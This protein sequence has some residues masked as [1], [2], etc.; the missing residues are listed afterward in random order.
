[1]AQRPRLKSTRRA[2]PPREWKGPLT[3]TL[4]WPPSVNGY[5]RAIVTGGRVRQILS[6]D[7]RAY[8]R[9]AQLRLF[10]QRAVR[11]NINTPVHVYIEAAEPEGRRRRDLDNVLKAALDAMVHAGI[12]EDDCY[13]DELR[14]KRMEFRTPTGHLWVSISEPG[15]S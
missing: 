2:E 7:A 6:A 4:P 14:I 3:F 11:P 15:G 12:L 9:N 5:W 1:M 13:V 8:R 10:V